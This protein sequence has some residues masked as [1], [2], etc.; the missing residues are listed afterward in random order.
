MIIR[1]DG[2]DKSGL[3]FNQSLK[4]SDIVFSTAVISKL[5]ACQQLAEKGRLQIDRMVDWP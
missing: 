1:K 5:H 4:A 3:S 2:K